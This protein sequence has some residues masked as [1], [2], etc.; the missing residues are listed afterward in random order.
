MILL[1]DSIYK[2]PSRKVTLF[3]SVKNSKDAVF[4]EEF[5][6]L[7]SEFKNFSVNY[8]VT[9]EENPK[10]NQAVKRRI[11]FEDITPYIIDMDKTEILI[12][13]SIQFTRDVWKGLKNTGL[14]EDIIYTEA[15]F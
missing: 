14:S 9:Q 4:C 10:I 13:G 12:C 5:G 15:F 11:N 8:F 1:K 2:N 3:H 7:E 6:K